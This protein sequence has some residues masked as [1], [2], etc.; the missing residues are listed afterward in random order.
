M[1]EKLDE[2][3]TSALLS[4]DSGDLAY[5]LKL[6]KRFEQMG[7]SPQH[8]SNALCTLVDNGNPEDLYQAG[9]AMLSPVKRRPARRMP[10]SNGARWRAGVARGPAAVGV[11]RPARRTAHPD[12]SDAFGVVWAHRREGFRCDNRCR[13]HRVA[14]VRA[15]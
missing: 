9:S 6:T 12:G 3:A 5:C 7:V 4:L 10:A 13:H 8:A 15:H 2:Q 11:H 1:L 14:G